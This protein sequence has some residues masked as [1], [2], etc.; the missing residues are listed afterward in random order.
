VANLS[1]YFGVISEPRPWSAAHTPV[2]FELAPV[3]K[4]FFITNASGFAQ[5]NITTPFAF[6]FVVGELILITFSTFYNSYH[7]I[8]Q[9]DSQ[10][11]IV[12]ET[13]YTSSDSGIVA[14]CP[15]ITFI[16]RSGYKVLE[17]YPTELPLTTIGTFTTEINQSL[18]A[19][20]FDVSGFLKSIFTIQPPQ[21]GIDF[22]K[23]N[24]FRLYIGSI[25]FEPYLVANAA[26]DNPDFD[27]IY[28]NTGQPLNSQETIYFNC[29][30]TINSVIEAQIIRTYINDGCIVEGFD[31]DDFDNDDFIINICT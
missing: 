22:T 1:Q 17:A 13:V 24:Q 12:L 7:R 2:V 18:N 4:G 6:D 5:L 8:K 23:F 10:T 16:L 31:G 27:T 29:G 19:Y 9:V 11:Q 3:A 26:I 25:E 30:E 14:N 28:A 20:R 21:A 15:K